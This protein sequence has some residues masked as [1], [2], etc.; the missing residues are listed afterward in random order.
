MDVY[1]QIEEFLLFGLY[2]ET[3]QLLNHQDKISYLQELKSAY[4][5]KDI[6][7]LDSIRNS[8]KLLDLLRLLSFQIGNEVSLNELSNALGI[9]KQT[10][11]RYLDLLENAFII[12]KLG[13]FSK[14]L[15]KEV[16]KS[17][18]YYFYDNGIRNAVI[19]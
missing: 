17:N 5:F 18:R 6:L 12:K 19:N 3:L 8:D 7:E 2:P 11:S 16:T 1:Q 4:L 9:A 10:V 14:N 13:G 15:R